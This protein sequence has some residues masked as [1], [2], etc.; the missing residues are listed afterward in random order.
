MVSQLA[1]SVWGFPGD[2]VV[3]T[4]HASVGNA[5]D[6]GS[7]PELGCPRG[8]NGNPLQYSCLGN[9]MDRGA[10]WATVYGVTKSRTQLSDFTHTK[11]SKSCYQILNV[12]KA[13]GKQIKV[14]K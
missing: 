14:T 10:W 3:K 11:Y 8:G 7:V 13:K 1:F 2:S 4:L 9:S 5:G 12:S 6:V